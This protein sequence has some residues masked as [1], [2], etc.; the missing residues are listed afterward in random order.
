MT[1]DFRI[2]LLGRLE[3]SCER[4]PLGPAGTKRRSLL[5][6]LALRANKVVGTDELVAGLW[7]ERPPRSATATVQTYVST[8]RKA[9]DATGRSGASRITTL[10]GG[11]RL[12]VAVDECDLLQF[13]QLA[14]R[15]RV[16]LAEGRQAGRAALEEALSL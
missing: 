1:E 9:F 13:L 11:Y 4:G 12:A 7:G 10:A 14:E 5:A 16:A 2:R 3:V 6:M 15:G 8:W